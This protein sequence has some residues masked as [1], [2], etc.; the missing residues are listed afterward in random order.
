MVSR[1]IRLARGH[2]PRV[3]QIYLCM[4]Q[5]T[6]IDGTGGILPKGRKRRAR[7][8]PAA[9]PHRH[10]KRHYR[11]VSDLPDALPV[12]EAELDLL[13]NALSAFIAELRGKAN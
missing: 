12:T 5:E 9:K 11:V 4:A 8:R 6:S 1:C 3:W 7:P 13:E 10:A 2:A